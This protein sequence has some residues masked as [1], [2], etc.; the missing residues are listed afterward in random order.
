MINTTTGQIRD[1]FYITGLAACPI[2]V[3]DAPRPVLFDGGVSCAGRLYMDA[4]RSALQD[5]Q[6]EILFL[7]HVHWD[8]CGAAAYLKKVFPGLKIAASPV[9][10]KILKNPRA[11]S[12]MERL[13]RDIMKDTNNFSDIDIFQLIDDPFAPFEVDIELEDGQ[14]FDLG[15]GTTVQAMATPG[16]TR[17]HFSYYL[18]ADN[19]LIAGEAAGEL[20]SSGA[21]LTHFLVDY[22]D[23][24]F[25]L[26]R[27]AALPLEILCQGHQFVFIGQED[28]KAFFARSISESIRYKDRIIEL[29]YEED[30]SIERVIHK[31]KSE[32]Y[33]TIPGPKQPE[34]PYLLNVTAQIKHLAGKIA[35]K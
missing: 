17:D 4:I 16:H 27:L 20:D 19:I 24:M 7:T 11:Q 29:L 26:R 35:V 22:E 14:V 6:P 23:Y 25:N 15:H 9:G 12:L 2:F 31:L 34:M 33:D 8:H 1:N 10:A 13:N 21:I 5:R 28:V 3:L 32:R 18:P 30:G